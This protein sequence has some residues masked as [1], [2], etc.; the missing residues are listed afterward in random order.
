[1]ETYLLNDR[2]RPNP[3]G[4]DGGTPE[5]CWITYRVVFMHEALAWRV[6]VVAHSPEDAAR[7]VALAQAIEMGSIL[8]IIDVATLR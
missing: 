7:A 6:D 8:A 2:D 1:M 5:A 4:F 3:V